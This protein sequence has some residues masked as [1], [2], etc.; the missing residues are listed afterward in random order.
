MRSKHLIRAMV[1][2]IAAALVPAIARTQDVS[3][4]SSPST[5]TVFK[6]FSGRVVKI[7]VIEN[8]SV[9]KA[10]LGSGFF[11]GG[12]GTIVTNY[13]VVAQIVN[14]PTRYHAE[15]T[16]GGETTQRVTVVGIDVIHDLAVLHSAARPA[17]WFALDSTAIDQGERLYSMGHPRDLGLSIVEGTY[18]GLLAHTLYPKIHFTGALNPGMSGGPTITADGRVIGI[19]VSTDG[20]G[21]SFLVPVARAKELLDRTM[22]TGYAVRNGLLAD[23]TQQ[24]LSYQNVY[25]RGMFLPSSPT[26]Q[27]GSYTLP[28]TP[29]PFFKCWA[30]AQRRDDLPYTITLHQCST[31][32]RLY[33]SEEQ[34]SGIA[35]LQHE[36]ITTTTLSRTQFYELYT[37][38][39]ALRESGFNGDE[40]D[41]TRFSCQTH[42]VAYNDTKL[43]AVFCVRAYKKLHG[44]YDAVVRVATLGMANSGVVTTLHL[45]GVSF[46]NA[47]TIGTRYIQRIS[48]SISHRIPQNNYHGSV[49]NDPHTV[50]RVR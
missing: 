34:W 8:G 10:S 22:R 36:L 4:S 35:A 41:V 6:R 16:G 37:T 20:N 47:K 27:L 18:N 24:I 13:H 42:N 46:E 38:H 48:Q 3:P 29:A 39:F 43:R 14:N 33:I 28:T 25:L 7:Q 15:M 30:D 40:E 1:T 19:N 45:S 12:D 2:L 44:L 26:V 31:D 21:I 17:L 32:D 5:P 9:A 11:V 49:L 23:A 50:A